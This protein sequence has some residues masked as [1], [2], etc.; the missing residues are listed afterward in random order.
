MKIP[1]NWLKEY[2]EIN[3]SK[4]EIADSFTALGLMLDKPA[5]GDVLDLEHRMD[6]S[7][8]L[9]I[10]GCARDLAAF[11]NLELKYPEMYNEKGKELP[12]N[13]KIKIDC[14]CPQKVNRFKTVVFKNITVKESPAWLKEKLESYGMPTKNNIVDI[15]NYVMIEFGQTMHA[16]DIDKLA[17]KEIILRDAKKGEKVTTLLG[18]TVEL[19]PENF[20]LTQN[21]IPTVIGGIV[22]G[23]DTGVTEST[24]NIVLDSGN[25]NQVF[26]RKASRKIKVQNESVLR[27]DKFLHPYL[28]EVAIKRATKLILDL[29]DG[30]FY[31]NYDW[32]PNPVEFKKQTLTFSRIEKL[33]GM[34]FEVSKIKNILNKLEYKILSENEEGYELEVPYFRTDV[35]VEDD[36]VADILRINGYANIP[37]ELIQSAP[38]KEITPEIFKFEERLRDILVNLGLHEHITDPLI[39]KNN[40]VSTQKDSTIVLENALSSDKSALR[41]SIKQTLNTVFETYKKHKIN[42][43]GIFEIGKVYS[44]T[45]NDKYEE[46]RFLEIMYQNQSLNL[47]QSSDNFKKVLSALL[48]ELEVEWVSA[49]KIWMITPISVS[50]NTRELQKISRTSNRVVSDIPNNTTEDLSLIV[51][52]G[53]EFGETYDILK[54]SDHV[55]DINVIE[56]FKIDEKSKSILVRLTLDTSNTQEI[57]KTLIDKLK[58]QGIKIRI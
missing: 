52:L 54:N 26:I 30:E 55:L 1:L 17:A 15:T 49:Q 11:E 36:V 19:V 58:T 7:D 20:V 16:Q 22:G 23:L 31:E 51:E 45:V 46:N 27:N 41:T 9:S 3:K 43:I 39:D 5:T 21:D 18:E 28:N 29:A 40:V 12:E 8:W 47:K 14:K 50:I 48:S 56:E 13:E 6:R 57:R 32:Y 35:E 44:K 38:P 37:F 25:Y 24:K 4:K 33:S 2:I 34:K 53:K 42:E 10:I